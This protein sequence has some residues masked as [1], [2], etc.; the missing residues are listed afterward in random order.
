M[1]SGCGWVLVAEWDM[2]KDYCGAPSQEDKNVT[3]FLASIDLGEYASAFAE[4]KVDYETLLGLH[5]GH[6]KEMGVKALGAR[7]KIIKAAARARREDRARL[8][9]ADQ[10]LNCAPSTDSYQLPGTAGGGVKNPDKGQPMNVCD[11]GP[12][13]T[14]TGKTVMPV[15]VFQVSSTAQQL[16]ARAA[17]LPACCLPSR[18]TR[19]QDI[20]GDGLPDLIFSAEDTET[21]VSAGLAG[22]GVARTSTL[23]RAGNWLALDRRRVWVR[24]SVWARVFG[25][26]SWQPHMSVPSTNE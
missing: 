9:A 19:S 3:A 6:L 22:T 2:T 8:G 10:N 18:C 16:R 4:H 23:A 26:P 17:A 7:L 14:G 1:N 15:G 20:N 21:N 13:A 5:Q 11:S 24:V 12:D 25:Q